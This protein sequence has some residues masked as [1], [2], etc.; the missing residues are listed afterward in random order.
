MEHNLKEKLKAKDFLVSGE[1][2]SLLYD[3]QLEMLI[4]DPQPKAIDLEKYYDSDA[5]ISHTDSKKGFFNFLYQKVKNYSLSRK[6]RLISKLN[7]G[8]GS[9][10]DVGAGTGEFLLTAKKTGWKVAGVEV[11]AKAK[12][13]A[14]TKGLHLNDNLE[15]YQNQ[16]FDVITLW[17][18]LEHIPNLEASIQLLESMLKE[19]GHLI[20]AVPNFKSYDANYYKSYWA[21]YDV[22]RHLWHFSKESI[23]KLSS[24]KVQLIKT[25]PLIF[26]SFYVSL[27]SEKYKTGKSFSIKSLFIGLRSN[28]KAKRT[29]EYSSIIYCLKKPKNQN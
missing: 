2:F 11:N 13:S 6:E 15:A 10:L 20:V 3:P 24:N 28:L 16:K 7:H 14:T 19:E 22:P 29:G 5:Y 12:N 23:P 26:D 1:E 17:H 4:T 21:A 27:L 18:V 9:L 25:L 8:K